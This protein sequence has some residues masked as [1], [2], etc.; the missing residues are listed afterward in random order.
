MFRKINLSPD[1][2]R[3]LCAWALGASV[4]FLWFHSSG[5]VYLPWISAS[6]LTVSEG[7][8]LYAGDAFAVND[9]G[10]RYRILA[11]LVAGY[12]VVPTLFMYSW[13]R[14]FREQTD[15]CTGPSLLFIVSGAITFILF[16]P[17]F[18]QAIE[19]HKEA[20]RTEKAVAVQTE[21]DELTQ[22]LG[23][24][25]YDAYLYRLLPPASGGGG[26][27]F[28]GYR[29]PPGAT[30]SAAAHSEVVQADKG[31]IRF[32]ETSGIFPGSAVTAEIDSTGMIRNITYE[33]IFTL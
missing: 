3:W 17:A 2:L 25:A 30:S 12:I 7:I 11:V 31:M 4:Y 28:A 32:R 27:S 15:R 10:D 33:G 5:E 23:R 6:S 20:V 14:L 26:D 13:R 22:D 8:R 18:W 21:K 24:L 9:A 19:V 1:T 16:V 29:P